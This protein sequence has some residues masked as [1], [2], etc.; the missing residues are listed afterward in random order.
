M[1]I[2][3][4]LIQLRIRW[5]LNENEYVWE[6]NEL[7]GQKCTQRACKRAVKIDLKYKR[8][9]TKS[10]ME[11]ARVGRLHAVK[12]CTRS[13]R[14]TIC[15]CN[16]HNVNQSALNLSFSSFCHSH[17]MQAVCMYA[18]L[19]NGFFIL[20]QWFSEMNPNFN[21]AFIHLFQLFPNSI[22]SLKFSFWG[23]KLQIS[24]YIFNETLILLEKMTI[25]NSNEFLENK[26][27]NSKLEK[28]HFWPKKL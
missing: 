15:K 4:N 21:V 11:M 7:Y 2:Y 18:F 16:N 10:R 5:K 3:Y 14:R 22:N 27:Q 1:E 8:K 23:L 17:S 13:D 26:V 25:S 6:N 20:K 19:L 28:T 12:T 9:K 24:T